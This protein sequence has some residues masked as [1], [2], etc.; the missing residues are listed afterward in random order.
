MFR[1]QCAGPCYTV[2]KH[3]K[4]TRSEIIQPATIFICL[5]ACQD[6][7]VSWGFGFWVQLLSVV[8]LDE[9]PRL[10]SGLGWVLPP[11]SNLWIM[12]IRIYSSVMLPPL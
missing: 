4:G 6:Y 5:G 7:A 10:A 1:V 8:F 9:G 11:R 12:N 3:F 2:K